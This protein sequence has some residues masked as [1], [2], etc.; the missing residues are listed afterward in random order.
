MS[1]FMNVGAG[2][3][4]ALNHCWIDSFMKTS[5]ISV[6]P[7]G[8]QDIQRVIMARRMGIGRTVQEAAGQLPD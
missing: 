5:I 1:R 6:H 7:G 3:V 2:L 8:T 4:P